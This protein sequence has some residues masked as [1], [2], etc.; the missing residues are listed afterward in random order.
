[1]LRPRGKNQSLA[2]RSGS[3]L[4]PEFYAKTY[5]ARET[6]E[7]VVG[8]TVSDHCHIVGAVAGELIRRLD[9]SLSH[10]LFPAGAELVAA[11]H[12][13]GK[14]CP[15]F[16][17]KI[18]QNVAADSG[19]IHHRFDNIHTEQ[20]RN[21]GGHPGITQ[22]TLEAAGV[23]DYI[24]E[25][26]GQH[27]GFSPQVG[28]YAAD[29]EI[30]GGASWLRER[31]NL[32]NRLKG[33]FRVE[34][35]EISTEAEARLVAG[36]T[37]VA[38]WI[39]SGPLFDDP[40][41]PWHERIVQ[42]VNLAGFIPPHFRT[43]LDFTGVFGAEYHPYPVQEQ[44][45]RAA[46]GPGIYILEAPMGMG[47]T[48]AA[49]YAAYRLCWQRQA[50]GI[51]FALPTQLTSNKI[52]QRF[53]AFLCAVLEED[54]PHRQALLL[55][56]KAWLQSTEFGGEGSPG[57]SWFNSAKRGL[58]APF[59]VGTLDQALMAAMNVK[60]GF[61]RAFGLA[62]KVVILDE[63][64]TYDAFT[65]TIIAALV[66]LLK[67][68]RCTVIILSATLDQTRRKQL[69]G[70]EPGQDGYPLV[71][72]HSLNGNFREQSVPIPT[73]LHRKITLTV[74][75]DTEQALNEALRRAEQGQQILWIENTVREA[76]ERYLDF[77]ARCAEQGV[78]CGLLHS[79][80]TPADRQCIEEK[81][82]NLFGKQGWK[83]RGTQGRLLIGTQVLEQ[84]LDIDADFLVSRFCPTDMLLQRLGRLW[85]HAQT[86]R[87][88]TAR[89]E[90]WILAPSLDKALQHPL[91]VFGDTARVYSP[92]I[93][94]R[95]LELWQHRRELCL[96]SDIRTFLKSTYEE[97]R[98]HGTMERLAYEL[99]HGSSRR[100][101]RLALQQLARTTLAVGGLT[102]PE[103]KAQTRY[104]EEESCD[105][106]LCREIQ[107]QPQQRRTRLILLCGAKLYLPWTRAALGR[108]QWRQLS[109][110]LMNQVVQVRTFQA[111]EPLPLDILKKLGLQHCFYLGRPEWDE[112][113]LRVA[114]VDVTGALQGYQRA[115][116]SEKYSLQYRDDLGYRVIPRE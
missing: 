83:S 9:A 69:L 6:G 111:P 44:F 52:Y 1:M 89:Q 94:C 43:D 116:L 70:K 28:M 109:V 82:V 95:S 33:A 32:L 103:T 12:D 56:G 49:L 42:A 7:L 61:V 46:D 108:R 76:Q 112:A 65:G 23:G 36:L 93:L 54:S 66:Q 18:F 13:V 62:G 38:D 19:A 41:N 11:V 100:I 115:S 30:F 60:H 16:Q 8:R 114:L 35:P 68:L 27:H 48:E 24:P 87:P 80:F 86:P 40:G 107:P 97:R 102:L 4:P 25:I 39:G 3:P 64:H 73:S 99:E 71:S 84:S 10:S 88:A 17:K 37:T 29:A 21:W 81:W 20:E 92:Y 101:G 90:A 74:N 58:L 59:A 50:R 26:G 63:V 105:L 110:Q 53:K 31:L 34:W 75:N 14:I 78:A 57:G 113:L 77:A 22:V 5:R 98:E 79:R 106:F 104:S 51:Y 85:R 47:K 91:R 72:A 2:R 55:H 67:S 15:T 96:P 45:I